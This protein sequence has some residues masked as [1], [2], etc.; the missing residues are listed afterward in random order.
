MIYKKIEIA[1]RTIFLREALYCFFSEK[2][3]V[4]LHTWK[5]VV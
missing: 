2:E 5:K 4:F 1:G 3:S